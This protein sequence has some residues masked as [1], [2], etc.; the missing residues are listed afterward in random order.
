[1]LQIDAEAWLWVAVEQIH[2]Q[3]HSNMIVAELFLRSSIRIYGQVVYR[4]GGTWYP[5]A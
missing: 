1:M 5:E 3:R 2:K 4:D